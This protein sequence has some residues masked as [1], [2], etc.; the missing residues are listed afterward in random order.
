M[1]WYVC[2]ACRVLQRECSGLKFLSD[3]LPAVMR[4]SASE[5]CWRLHEL[6][7]RFSVFHTNIVYT[8]SNEKGEG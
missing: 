7:K 4:G 2:G 8:V 6:K 1:W 3:C 5:N